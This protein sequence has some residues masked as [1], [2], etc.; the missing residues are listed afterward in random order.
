[1]SGHGISDHPL[2]SGKEPCEEFLILVNTSH[3]LTEDIPEPLVPVH[4]RTPSI[5]MRSSAAVMLSRLMQ[6]IHGWKGIVPV[7]GWRSRE[8]Q[9]A[10]WDSSLQENGLTFTQKYVALPG[11]SEHQT[12]LAIDLGLRQEHID[13]ICPEFPDTG[14][15][16]LF[17]EKAPDY[18]FILRYPPGKEHITGISHEPWHFRYVGRPHAQIMEQKGLTLEEYVALIHMPAT[19]DKRGVL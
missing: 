12:G 7:S 13:F 14:I 1:M 3:A 2:Y 17:R 10:I 16:R 11:H 9:Q 6:D 4:P 15:C 5:L 8:E 18:G 19:A